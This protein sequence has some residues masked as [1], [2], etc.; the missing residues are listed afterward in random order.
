MNNSI[1]RAGLRVGIRVT[2]VGLAAGALVALAAGTASA[3]VSAVSPDKPSKG[4]DAEIV[5]RVPNEEANANTTRLEVD[6]STTDPV[7]DAD[8]RPL[9]GWTA[10]VNTATLAKPVPEN[11][12]TVTK[13]LT[14]IVW[15]AAPGNAIKPGEFQ[16]F[17]FRVEGLP[18]STDEFVMPAVQTY[19]NGDVVRWDQKTVAGQQEPEHPA[20]HLDLA[21]AGEDT[22]S[23]ATVTRP[24][25]DGTARWLGGSGLVVG[26]LGLGVGGVGLARTR[27]KVSGSER[28]GSE[29]T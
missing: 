29:S 9:S 4:G 18:N 25:T 27:R 6:F 15:T 24:S 17:A 1:T 28:K 22:S 8:T 26:A 20:P 13:A 3:H 16:E 19:S 10:K 23:T 2:G 11:N 21:P 12:A 7:G 5:L 14:S